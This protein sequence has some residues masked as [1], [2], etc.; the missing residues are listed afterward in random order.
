MAESN[1]IRKPRPLPTIIL[2]GLAI[3]VLDFFDASIFFPLYYGISFIDVW[4]GP[5]SGLI[6]RDA[7]RAGGLNTALLGILM[8]FIVAFCI[9]TVYYLFSRFIPFLIRRPVISGLL[10]GVAAHF[11]MQYF[12]IPLSAIGRVPPWP[13]IGSLLNSLI[14]HAFLVGLPVALIASWSARKLR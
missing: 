2:G 11:I 5:A 9:A 1:G 8:H 3:G 10:F 4:H 13:P 7:A 12:V 14:G 6:G